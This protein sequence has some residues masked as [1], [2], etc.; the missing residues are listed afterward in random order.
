MTGVPHKLRPIPLAERIGWNRE[1]LIDKK[2]K[3]PLPAWQRGWELIAATDEDKSFPSL[4]DCFGYGVTLG[5]IQR[6]KWPAFTGVDPSSAKRK[7][8]AISTVKIDPCTFRRYP[9]DIRY[10]AWKMDQLLEQLADVNSIF[11]PTVIMVED[12]AVQHWLVDIIQYLKLEFW[13]KV[14]ATTTT[15]GKKSSETIGLPGMQVEFQNKGWVF[16]ASEF[17]GHEPGH[18]TQGCAWCRLIYEFRYHP[19]AA[20]SDGVMATWFARQGIEEHG[21]VFD[22]DDVPQGVTNR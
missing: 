14:E 8:N 12:N 4:D 22:A 10:G 3:T 17:E 5:E 1:A 19:V 7:G 6:N 16:P 13:V 18:H 9:I 11:N 20:S 2:R 21:Y 15:G